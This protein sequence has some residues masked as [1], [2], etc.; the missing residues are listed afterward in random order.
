MSENEDAE[1]DAKEEKKEKVYDLSVPVDIFSIFRDG[2][3]D[4]AIKK[5]ISDHLKKLIKPG[6]IV[7]LDPPYDKENNT[8]FTEYTSKNIGKSIAI[9]IDNEVYYA[10]QIMNEIN[11]GMC[12]ITG[13]FTLSETNILT[14]LIDNG[15]LPLEFRI[16]K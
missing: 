3:S 2:L 7:Y 10:P 16:K 6:D 15:E 9:V 4:E 8:S 11:T 12:S 14:S 1:K 13:D 5:H